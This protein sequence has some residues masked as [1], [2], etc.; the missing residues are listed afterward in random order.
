VDYY[1]Q[2]LAIAPDYRLAQENLAAARQLLT[3]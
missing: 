2:A 3:Q 1:E